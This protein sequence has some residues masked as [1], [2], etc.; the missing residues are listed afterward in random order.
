METFIMLT[1]LAPGAVKSPKT[2]EDLER[3]AMDAIRANCPEVEWI[4]SYAVLGPYDYVDIFQAPGIE[5]ATR[6]S[7]LIRTFGHAQTEIWGATEWD[8]FKD[9][10]RELPGE[11]GS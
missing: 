9:V 3:K 2:L 8:R 1:Q 10:V 7:T 4:G 11:G 5:S 6:V